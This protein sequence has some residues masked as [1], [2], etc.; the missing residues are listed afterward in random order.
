[1]STWLRYI[2]ILLSEV[3]RFL[4][5]ESLSWVTMPIR[6]QRTLLINCAN[7]LFREAR[8]PQTTDIWNYA[9]AELVVSSCEQRYSEDMLNESSILSNLSEKFSNILPSPVSITCFIHYLK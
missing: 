9:F 2:F 3:D 8:L 7:S 4:K 5:S 1:M 6:K